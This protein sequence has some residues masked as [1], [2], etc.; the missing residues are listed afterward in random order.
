[1]AF[2]GL[3]AP[4]VSQATNGLNL[5]GSGGISSALA[6]ADTA[7]A[8]DF[9]AMNTNPAGMTQIRGES[10][11]FSLSVLRAEVTHRDIQNGNNKGSESDPLLIPN[12]GYIRRLTGTPFTLGIGFFTVGGNAV[13]FKDLTTALG[14]RDKRGTILRHYKL[15]PTI[16]YQATEKLSLGV[17][18]GI[19]YADASL[20]Y[21][22]ATPGGFETTGTCN[23]ANG[24]ALPGSCSYA[25]GFTPKFGAMYR[26]NDMVTLGLAY[27]MPV[28]L[29]L[30]HGKIAK[31]QR[32]PFTGVGPERVTYDAEVFGLKWADDIAAGIA[33]RPRK[34]LLIAMKF[35]WINWDAALNNLVI[36]LTNGDNAAFPRDT[37]VLNYKWR[38]QYVGAIGAM[39]DVTDYLNVRGGYNY[40]NNPV[41]KTTLD[42]TNSNIVE[43]HIVAGFSFRFTQ[44]LVLDATVIY[45]VQSQRTYD[46]AASNFGPN[47]LLQG[48]GYDVGFTLTY[49]N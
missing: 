35:Q 3:L 14:N 45:A 30:S 20:T 26:V 43:H 48:G 28:N 36:Q 40:G 41:P 24:I 10:A 44:A 7:V 4:T 6:G 9:T 42:P 39:Y 2:L 32:N 25:L 21:F 5:I 33:I 15:A 49:W 19:S 1:L 31:N 16:A 27:T 37:V 47:S 12:L 23:R 18:L 22:P 38:D 46:S 8:T 17:S 11:G 29:P 13:E 34:D